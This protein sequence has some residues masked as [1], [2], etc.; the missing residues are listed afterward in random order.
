M[1]TV[2]LVVT[3]TWSDSLIV[4]P[5]S[6]WFFAS[7][8]AFCQQAC[9]SCKGLMGGQTQ[10]SALLWNHGENDY[11]SPAGTINQFCSR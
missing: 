8:R 9:S 4:M 1:G 11:H 2:P 3:V 6:L 5:N 7:S 10:R